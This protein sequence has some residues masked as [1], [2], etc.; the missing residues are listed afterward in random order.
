MRFLIATP[1][2]DAATDVAGVG[3]A[4]RPAGQSHHVAV[5]AADRLV[6]ERQR[7]R[8]ADAALDGRD[9]LAAPGR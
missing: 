3:G 1:L 8:L 5:V 7:G 6:G 4:A 2:A 9:V